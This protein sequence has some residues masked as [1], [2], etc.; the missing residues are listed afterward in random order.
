MSRSCTVKDKK[1]ARFLHLF[2]TLPSL[3]MMGWVGWC[4]VITV[5]PSQPSSRQFALLYAQFGLIP[6]TFQPHPG[7]LTTDRPTDP[8]GE[9][10]I[11]GRR[12]VGRLRADSLY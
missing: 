7:T 4:K 8:D 12:D 9:R 10:G 2:S 6:S 3:K 11:G 5:V 1:F